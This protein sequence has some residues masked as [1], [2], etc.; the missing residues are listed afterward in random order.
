MITGKDTGEEGQKRVRKICQRIDSEAKYAS[1]IYVEVN[2][3]HYHVHMKYFLALDGQMIE[4]TSG[5]GNV[6]YKFLKK[7]TRVQNTCLALPFPFSIV[8]SKNLYRID[9]LCFVVY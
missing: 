3:E 4:I 7:S 5:L 8:I 6:N 9:I 2:G 1:N